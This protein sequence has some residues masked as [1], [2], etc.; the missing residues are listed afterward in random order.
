MPIY[1]KIPVDFGR[2]EVPSTP[3]QQPRSGC[4]LGVLRRGETAVSEACKYILSLYV[5][6]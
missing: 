4:C 3:T 5:Q 2:H 6:N 1:S